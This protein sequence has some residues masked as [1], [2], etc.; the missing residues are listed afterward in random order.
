MT[1]VERD[2]LVALRKAEKKII[3][4]KQAA[5]ELGLSTR[6][7]KRL[8]RALKK[9][10]DEAVVHRLRGQASNRRSDEKVEQEAMK[11]LSSDV[12]RGLLLSSDY[13]LLTVQRLYHPGWI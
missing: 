7:V 5:E 2:R 8:V 13:V 4:Q 6:Q 1:Q 10:G 12:Y 3:T 9:R 11:I